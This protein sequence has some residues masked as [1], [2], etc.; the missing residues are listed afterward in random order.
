MLS[1]REILGPIFSVSVI[2]MASGC[3]SIFQEGTVGLHIINNSNE[4]HSLNIEFKNGD[5]SVFEDE[6]QV[7]PNKELEKNDV[8]EPGEYTVITTSNSQRETFEFWMGGCNKN[9]LIIEIQ[10]TDNIDMFIDIEC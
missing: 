2:G 7:S 4:E 6:Y 9:A 10:D 5:E 1:R 3:L 8:V